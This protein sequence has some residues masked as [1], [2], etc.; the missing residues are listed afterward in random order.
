MASMFGQEAEASGF[1]CLRAG[2]LLTR[3]DRLATRALGG[4]GGGGRQLHPLEPVT[5]LWDREA[6][7][8][9]LAL[10]WMLR[11]GDRVR[12]LLAPSDLLRD[13]GRVVLDGGNREADQ[14]VLFMLNTKNKKPR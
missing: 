3:C 9:F 13:V 11:G 4:R 6:G 2:P 8:I 10:G 7:W 5:F 14:V 1:R 12:A